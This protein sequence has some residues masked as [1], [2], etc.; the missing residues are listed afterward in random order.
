MTDH[1]EVRFTSAA[2]RELADV[3]RK[4]PRRAV[5]LQALVAQVEENGW[6]LSVHAALIK[7][8][9]DASCIGELRD[10][11]SGGYRL[12]MFWHDTE[13]AREIWICRVL[14]KS[15]VEGRRRMSDLCDSIA[16]LRKRF[17]EESE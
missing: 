4:D 17:I 3:A 8:L 13:E 10:V 11:G 12:L 2:A 14:P 15:A 1:C 6:T 7:V 16:A 5:I 9:R